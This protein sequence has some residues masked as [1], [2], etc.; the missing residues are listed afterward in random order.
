MGTVLALFGFISDKTTQK[1]LV[2][3][4]TYSIMAA[5]KSGF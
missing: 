3:S 1:E 2:L 4:G 5:K